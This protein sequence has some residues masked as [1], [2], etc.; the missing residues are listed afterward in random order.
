[1]T[2]ICAVCKRVMPEMPDEMHAKAVAQSKARGDWVENP[3]ER[4]IVCDPCWQR[5]IRN[6]WKPG[7]N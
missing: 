1:M 4:V 7:N 6:G 3:A 2:I 5:A